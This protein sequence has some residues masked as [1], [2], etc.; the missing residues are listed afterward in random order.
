VAGI[1]QQIYSGIFIC[2]V[3]FK[4]NGIFYKKIMY[5]VKIIQKFNPARAGQRFND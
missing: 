2:Q 3:F 4:K 1:E 5:R